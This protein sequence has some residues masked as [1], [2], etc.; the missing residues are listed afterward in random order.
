[1]ST[2]LQNKL[3]L[4]HYQTNSL[5]N[6]ARFT[7]Y[8]SCLKS[9]TLTKITESLPISYNWIGRQLDRVK[10]F[11]GVALPFYLTGMAIRQ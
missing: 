11:G 2:L 6:V 10:H 9:K 1:M 5:Q 7:Y 4:N 8:L 3:V